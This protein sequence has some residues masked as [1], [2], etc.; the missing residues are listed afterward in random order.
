[1][2]RLNK[3]IAGLFVFGLAGCATMP[4]ATDFD[5]SRSYSQSKDAVWTD[6][7]TF[8]ATNNIQ[9]KTIE[10]VSGVIYAER[11]RFDDAIADCGEDPFYPEISRI[12]S[13]NVLVLSQG[14]QTSVTVTSEYKANRLGPYN[15]PKTTQCLS[16]GV[17]ERRILDAI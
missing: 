8:F 10:K 5:N 2:I 15:E 7:V 12:A 6:L 9:I 11:G 16:T 14:A 17:L 4:V 13:F 3:G 1:M